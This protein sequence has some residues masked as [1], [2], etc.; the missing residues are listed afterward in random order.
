[1]E[2]A[3]TSREGA[4]APP[5]RPRPS[6][7][8]TGKYNKPPRSSVRSPASSRG[9]STASSRGSSTASSRSS[10]TASSRSSSVESRSATP[11]SGKPKLTWMQALKIWNKDH[12]QWCVPRRGSKEYDEVKKIQYASRSQ[13]TSLMHSTHTLSQSMRDDTLSKFRFT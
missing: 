12:D 7:A 11:T 13:T 5:A 8:K 9:S 6:A 3:S 10:S 2:R 4:K 1:M